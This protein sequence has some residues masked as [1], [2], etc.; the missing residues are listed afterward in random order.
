MYY[1]VF[2]A[3]IGKFYEADC[4]IVLKTFINE[5]NSLDWQLWY[6]IG[7]T[8]TLDKKACSAI[9][10]V[11]LRNL[12]GA[13]CRSI[14]EEMEDESEEFMDLFEN[15]ISYIEGGRTTSGFYSV[16]VTEYERKLYRASGAHAIHMERVEVS[17]RSLDRRYVYLLDNG[18][19]IFVWV[20]K[21]ARGTIRTKSRLVA[22]KINKNERKNK[23]SNT[24][25]PHG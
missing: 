6:W 12:L 13:E 11:N 20:G 8:T 17:V 14:R 3:L 25:L 23:A 7:K 4:Y 19:D 9:H 24:K 5:S 15:G 2:S 22:E 18:I 21:L 16:E 1:I 10:A